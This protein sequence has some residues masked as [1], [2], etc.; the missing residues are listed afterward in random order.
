MKKLS[1]LL[2]TAMVAYTLNVNAAQAE[3][4]KTQK[5]IAY[6]LKNLKLNAQQ[7]KS[8]Q[9]IL[10]AYCA[11]IKAAKK[12]YEEMKKK[13][14]NDIDKGVLTDKAAEALL[15]AKFEAESKELEV[16]KSYSKKFASVVSPKKVYLTFSL[17]NDKMSKVEGK[18]KTHEDDED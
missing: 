2:A 17:I 18:K 4:T 12:K 11:D 16:K 13:Y 1:F 5:R 10:T 3:P 15:D 8:L 9:P 14:E 7:Q 6:T